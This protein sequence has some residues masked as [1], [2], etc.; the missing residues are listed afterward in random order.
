MFE[1]KYKLYWNIPIGTKV[2]IHWKGKTGIYKITEH[3]LEPYCRN[4]AV[5]FIKGENAKTNIIAHQD[6]IDHSNDYYVLL[7]QQLVFWEEI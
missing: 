5:R 3:Q 4:Y 1:Q 2:I 6:F 7:R